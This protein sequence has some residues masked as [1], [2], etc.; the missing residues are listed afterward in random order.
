MEC[1]GAEFSVGDTVK[2]LVRKA[3]SLNTPVNVGVIDYCYEAHD[4]DW[5]IIYSNF[6]LKRRML[7]GEISFLRPL[8]E[9]KKC[10]IAVIILKN[11]VFCII[12]FNELL[13]FR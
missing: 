1:C 12:L 7:L 6:S 13:Y 9:A 5:Q 11:G 3:E 4:S 8:V 10:E 2:W